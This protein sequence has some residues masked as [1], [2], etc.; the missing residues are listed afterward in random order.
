MPLGPETRLQAAC[1]N[2][3]YLLYPH[4]AGRLFLNHNN[5][6]GPK[7]GHLLRQ[8]GLVAGVADMTL[9][10]DNGAVFIE[11]KTTTSTQ[12]K[13]QKQWQKIA[14]KAGYRYYLVRSVQQFQRCLQQN[15]HAS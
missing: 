11:F 10:G 12:N 14:E 4:A 8:M 1:V 6:R 7:H 2:L 9:L 5:P 3:F 13:N 15:L